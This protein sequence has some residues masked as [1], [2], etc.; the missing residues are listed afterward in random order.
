MRGAHYPYTDAIGRDLFAAVSKDSLAA[1]V[2]SLLTCGGD[3]IDSADVPGMLAAELD[4]LAAAG[5]VPRPLP[6]RFH[7]AASD[8][9]GVDR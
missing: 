6:A 4:S 7:R 1:V 2:V 8:L 3:T 5:V 9:D